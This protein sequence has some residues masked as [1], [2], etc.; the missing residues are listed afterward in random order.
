MQSTHFIVGSWYI[1]KS[2]SHILVTS[3]TIK[4]VEGVFSYELKN[5]QSKILIDIPESHKNSHHILE[6]KI[7]SIS[8]NK[9]TIIFRDNY[10]DGEH[11]A[12]KLK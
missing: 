11:L 12:Y 5:T 10:A 2:D 8:E 6:L 3:K 9:D 4:T 1:P 7:L